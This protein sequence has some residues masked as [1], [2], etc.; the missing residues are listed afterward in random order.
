MKE[1]PK[2][3][4]IIQEKLNYYLKELKDT[5]LYI[6]NYDKYLEITNKIKELNQEL[7]INETRWLEVLEIEENFDKKNQ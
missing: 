5:N 3:I 7:Q 1:L 6:N 2:K 4:S